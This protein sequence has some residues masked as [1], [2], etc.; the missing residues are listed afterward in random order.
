MSREDN[1]SHRTPA[2]RY[3]V[4]REQRWPYPTFVGSAAVTLVLAAF[5]HSLDSWEPYALVVILLGI[6]LVRVLFV[7]R[8]ARQATGDN[9]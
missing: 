1:V 6:A 5:T 3:Q 7:R 8:L 9:P 4:L 2:Q